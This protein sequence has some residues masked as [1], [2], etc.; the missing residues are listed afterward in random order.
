MTV[1][2]TILLKPVVKNAILL[3]THACWYNKGVDFDWDEANKEHIARHGVTPNEA[4]EA[5]TDPDRMSFSA[6]NVPQ[7]LR[8]AY[9]GAT[10]AGRILV[11]VYTKRAGRIRVV[12]ARDASPREK[13]RYRR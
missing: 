13:R 11:V 7:E 4:E 8:R 10:E 9:L 12:T 3:C 5:L 6:R 2:Y 1:T